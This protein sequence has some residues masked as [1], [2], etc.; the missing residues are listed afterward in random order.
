MC[1]IHWRLHVYLWIT[2]L[3]YIT[4]PHTSPKLFHMQNVS[5]DYMPEVT[6]QAESLMMSILIIK[7]YEVEVRLIT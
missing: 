2:S 4:H 5:P 6:S 1:E 3:D 7:G